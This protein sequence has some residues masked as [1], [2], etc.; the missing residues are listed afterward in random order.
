[1]RRWHGV[2]TP[3]SEAIQPRTRY[4]RNVV[5]GTLTAGAPRCDGIVE[6][7]WPSRRHVENPFLFYGAARPWD[8]PRNMFTMLRAACS[9]L[10]I[11][12]VRTTPASE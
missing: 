12:R 7:G 6:E 4:I 8:L 1:M 2:M 5:L 11:H 9:F 10:D 3:V